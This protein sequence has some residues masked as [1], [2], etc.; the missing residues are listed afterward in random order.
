MQKAPERPASRAAAAATSR[1]ASQQSRPIKPVANAPPRAPVKPARAMLPPKTRADGSALG[2]PPNRPTAGGSSKANVEAKPARARPALTQPTA[3]QLA[4]VKALV[5][6]KTGPKKVGALP[7][8]SEGK[9][10]SSNVL[11]KSTKANIGGSSTGTK[12]LAKPTKA[13]VAEIQAA[14][15]VPLPPSPKPEPVLIPL[16]DPTPCELDAERGDVAEGDCPAREQEPVPEV[17]VQAEL[18]QPAQP[19]H[20]RLPL[21][22]SSVYGDGDGILCTPMHPE[23]KSLGWNNA[24][25]P[26]SA[27]LTSIQQGFEFSP[28]SPV[29]PP[30]T[31]VSGDKDTMPFATQLF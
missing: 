1:P 9:P 21:L 2:G 19:T 16:P 4:K 14:A 23:V 13:D 5:I 25:T 29:S 10:T 6:N 31:Y 3:S 8:R 27:L 30:Y 7:T 24:K 18:E 20:F 15:S 12:K 28:S 11:S 22:D 17:A 26:I